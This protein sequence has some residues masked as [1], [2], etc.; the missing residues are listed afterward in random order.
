MAGRPRTPSVLKLWNLSVAGKAHSA[1]LSTVNAGITAEIVEKDRL[2]NGL[3]AE[4]KVL[5]AKLVSGAPDRKVLETFARTMHSA[6][7]VSA[8]DLAE[9]GFSAK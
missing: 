9:M 2:V 1:N 5:R 6:G 7:M 8:E 3:L 4:I